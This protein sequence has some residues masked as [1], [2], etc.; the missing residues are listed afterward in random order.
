MHIPDGYLGP[1]TCAVL[2]TAMVP[3]WYLAARKV[4]KTLQAKEIPLL[5]LGAA[6]TFVIMMFNIPIPGGST[7]HMV[8]AVVVASVLG[9]WTG[10][11]ALSLS[12]TIQALL[13]GD[14]GITTLGANCFNLAFLMPFTGYYVYQIIAAGNTG[15]K[16]RWVAL[17][18]AGYI[19]INIA[20][21]A[22]A[23][24]LG[25]Q[26][27]IASGPDGK[28]LYA[29]YPLTVT[30]PG[31]LF[32]HLLF[33]GPVEAIGTAMVVSYIFKVNE[34][35][36]YKPTTNPLKPLWIGLAILII[37]TPLGLLAQGTAWGEGASEELLAFL[38]YIP[39]GLK[40][41]EGLWDS[42]MPDY[43]LP[44][45]DGPVESAF[46]YIISAAIGSG[47]IVLTI[48]LVG[49]VWKKG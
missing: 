1:K 43:N 46:G 6:F 31:M 20:A 35:L 47:I 24:E 4:Q 39:E 29:P 9:P 48:Y 15:Q 19:S 26:P 34:S 22:V 2:Y 7:G 10:V 5:A 41:L 3:I 28:P 36:L 49:R 8:G 13:F 42:L 25:I 16:R 11:V 44:G 40:R 32:T 37:L 45:W 23:I 33:F 17:F 21:I 30:I 27:M 12:L 14:G 18:L 38:G